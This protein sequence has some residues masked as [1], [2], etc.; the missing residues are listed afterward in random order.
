[1]KPGDNPFEILR[2]DPCSTEAEIVAQ[3]GRLRQRCTEEEQLTS[4]RQAVQA[5][6]SSAEERALWALLTHPV[7]E[8]VSPTLDRFIAAFRRPPGP[9]DVLIQELMAR[10]LELAPEFFA[11]PLS[12]S[13]EAEIR[14]Q[15]AQMEWRNLM[16]TMTG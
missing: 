12:A 10:A 6:T 5:L 11:Q 14:G 3:A 15:F 1:M 2:L 8:Y 16:R 4:I 9:P 13:A 7:P